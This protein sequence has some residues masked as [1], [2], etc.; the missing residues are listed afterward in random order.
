MMIIPF[1][2][3]LMH[4]V[5]GGASAEENDKVGSSASFYDGQGDVGAAESAIASVDYLQAIN[6]NG[7]SDTP[8]PSTKVE[9]QEQIPT[10][11][12]S[13]ISGR[14]GLNAYQPNYYPGLDPTRFAIPRPPVAPVPVPPPESPF[15]IPMDFLGVPLEDRFYFTRAINRWRSVVVSS[16]GRQKVGW[17][18]RKVFKWATGCEHPKW[19]RGTYI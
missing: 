2:F 10:A 16:F 4:L 12:Q 14:D 13:G 15:K 6:N 8:S 1:V 11:V 17:G 9:V 5:M 7:S 3:I 18:K 19:V